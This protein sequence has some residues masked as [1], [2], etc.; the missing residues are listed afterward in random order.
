[1]AIRE[2][3]WDCPDCGRVRNRGPEKHCAGCGSPRSPHVPFYLP[4]DA[5]EVTDPEALRRAK[6]GPDWKCNFCGADNAAGYAHCTGCG[7][8]ADGTTRRPVIEYRDPPPEAEPP[9]KPKKKRGCLK[10]GCLGMLLTFLALLLVGGPEEVE[11]SVTGF[12][13]ERT[14]TLE[15]LV[16]EVEE[17][18]EDQLPAGARILERRQEQ[19]TVNKVQIGTE[20]RTR[21]VT[22]REQVGTEQVKVGVR[23][24][25]N[26]YFEDIFEERPV[27]ETHEREESY[28]APVYRGDPVFDTRV[29]FEI[30]RWKQSRQIRLADQGRP[31]RWLEMGLDRDERVREVRGTYTVYFAGP[32]GKTLHFETAN[33]ELWRTIREG[34]RYRVKAYTGSGKV[35]KILGSL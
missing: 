28:E 25:G 15:Q 8:S 19:R 17:A 18:W 13:W 21:T 34:G 6:A 24:L 30:D 10:V 3:A 16:T 11:V 27:Y 29:R 23:D 4:E 5:P 2:G 7:G 32:E 26:G 9:P 1:V 14:A 35:T 33:E 22:E 31:G 12:A 20:T